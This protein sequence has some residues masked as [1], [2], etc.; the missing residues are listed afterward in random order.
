MILHQNKLPVIRF[1]PHIVDHITVDIENI[2]SII[3]RCNLIH[4]MD[5]I[6]AFMSYLVLSLYKPL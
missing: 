1:I 3:L 4:K 2:S 6:H 5:N